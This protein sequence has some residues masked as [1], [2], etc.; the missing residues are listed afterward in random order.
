VNYGNGNEKLV[1]GEWKESY[2]VFFFSWTP[3]Q[4]RLILLKKCW[5][6]SVH[7]T[8]REVSMFHIS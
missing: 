8:T 7:N 4:K 5:E 1:I 6:V 3:N 2:K